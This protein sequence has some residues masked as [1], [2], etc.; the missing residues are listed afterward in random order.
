MKKNIFFIII[1][2][3]ISIS[4]YRFIKLNH[5]ILKEKRYE[6]VNGNEYFNIN[7]IDFKLE[8]SEIL[9][10]LHKFNNTSLKVLIKVN[11]NGHIDKQLF[12]KSFPEY[13]QSSI[14]LNIANKDGGLVENICSDVDEFIKDNTRF[15]EIQKGKR[16]LEK[17]EILLLTFNL[18][19]HIVEDVKNNMCT[20]KLVFPLDS[21]DIKFDYIKLNRYIK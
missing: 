16:Y 20:A 19:K 13:Y 18:N 5:E 3:F 17:D 2:L 15:I 14:V 8:K 21:N 11:K 4:G 6:E 7:G 1:I 9:Y 10:N 12:K